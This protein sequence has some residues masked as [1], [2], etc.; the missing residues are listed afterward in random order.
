MADPTGPSP[1]VPGPHIP[2][3]RPDFPDFVAAPTSPERDGIENL[4]KWSTSILN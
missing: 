3:P 1:A 2:V 4:T